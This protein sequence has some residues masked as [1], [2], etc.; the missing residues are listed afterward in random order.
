MEIGRRKPTDTPNND[1]LAFLMPLQRG[2]RPDTE[3][4]PNESGN[5]DLTLCRET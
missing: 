4:S 3:L 5:R 2:T 1:L